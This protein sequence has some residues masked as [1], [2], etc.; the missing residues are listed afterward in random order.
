MVRTLVVD[1]ERGQRQ[2]IVDALLRVVGVTVQGAVPSYSAAVRAMFEI[3]PDIVVMGTELVDGNALELLVAIRDQLRPPDV[4]VVGPAR[5]SLTHNVW[6]AT[7]YVPNDR[8]VVR[9]ADAVIE[10]ARQRTP[11]SGEV[12]VTARPAGGA[13]I[14]SIRRAAAS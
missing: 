3:Q 6:G 12:I 9:V 14:T 8:S 11:R 4:I 1:G 7:R 10:I 2:A 13:A 5:Q